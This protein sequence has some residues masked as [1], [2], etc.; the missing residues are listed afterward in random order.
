[1]WGSA[2]KRFYIVTLIICLLLVLFYTYGLSVEK[3]D[4]AGYAIEAGV[5]LP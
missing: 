2:M 4:Q 3:N 5:S 1:M